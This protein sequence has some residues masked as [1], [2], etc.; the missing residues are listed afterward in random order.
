MV[1][2]WNIVRNRDMIRSRLV[3]GIQMRRNKSVVESWI[4][5]RWKNIVCSSCYLGWV[6]VYVERYYWQASGKQSWHGCTEQIPFNREC[7][8]KSVLR[9][10]SKPDFGVNRRSHRLICLL[11]ICLCIYSFHIYLCFPLWYVRN[12]IEH[13]FN[14]C[15]IFRKKSLCW[16][17]PGPH[18][19]VFTPGQ[20][21]TAFYL[22]TCAWSK[23]HWYC[24]KF[25]RDALYSTLL[26]DVFHSSLK[27]GLTARLQSEPLQLHLHRLMLSILAVSH[28]P[29]LPYL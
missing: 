12:R 13:L 4:G 18:G 19:A 26:W 27:K 7:T 16:R 15:V 9:K 11:L 28:C 6:S 22:E 10:W 20:H 23:A 29:P 25:Q 14:L 17:K 8:L 3:L 5:S 2:S 1:S 24:T 21:F